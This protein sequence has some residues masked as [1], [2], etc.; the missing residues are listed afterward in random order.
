MQT[1]SSRSYISNREWI[2][3]AVSGEN[4]V[5]RGVSALD[6][7]RFFSGY[8]NERE[9]DVYALYA[10]SYDNINYY[11]VDSFD[12]IDYIRD[13]DVLCSTFG[14]AV[15]DILSDFGNADEKAL[16]NALSNYYFSN[17]ES[18]D[19]LCIRPEN[20]EQFNYIR[21]WAVEYC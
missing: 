16:A 3:D 6:Y 10:G 5:L 15:N 12:D 8:H 11:I 7:M 20:M 1:V 13:G 17:G 2:R 21:D 9:I 19:G 4:I 18:F 14:Q